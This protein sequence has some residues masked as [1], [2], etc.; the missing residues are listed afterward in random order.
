RQFNASVHEVFATTPTALRH[1]RGPAAGSRELSL[2]LPYRQPMDTR[3]TL[4]FLG[5]RAIPGVEAYD[6]E[7]YQR[8]LALPFGAGVVTLRPATS[9]VRCELRLDDLRDLQAAVQRAR[10]LLDLDADPVGVDAHLGAEVALAPMVKKLPGLRVPGSVN[11]PELAVRAVLGQQVSLAGARTLASRLV[12]R[13]GRRLP[14]PAG[15][16]THAFPSADALA[17]ADPATFGLPAA[18]GR[19]LHHLAEALA[20]G[21]V[22]L[23]PGADRAATSV[24]LSRLPGIGPWTAGYVAMRA[25]GDPDVFLASD[26]G[27]RRGAAALGLPDAPRALA[28]AARAWSPWRSYAALLLWSAPAPG[29]PDPRRRS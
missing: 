9:H 24:G 2:R 28:D 17:G 11:G 25:L 10:R 13:Y 15:E 3:Q 4:D 29:T 7:R 19:A 14:A 18:R 1:R 12:A 26:L 27:A 20:S 23:H 5:R 22:E 21:R 6:G 16:V 8:S